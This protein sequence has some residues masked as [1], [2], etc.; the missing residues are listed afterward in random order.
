MIFDD[1]ICEVVLG[2]T[3]RKAVKR[4]SEDNILA[5]GCAGSGKTRSFVV[6]NIARVEGDAIIVDPNGEYYNQC[7]EE[8]EKKGT[9]VVL[10]D[11]KDMEDTKIT[12]NPFVSLKNDED[13]I[14]VFVDSFFGNEKESSDPFWVQSEKE[15][16]KICTR[17]MFST[18][19]K[20]D[21]NFETFQEILRNAEKEVFPM[22]PEK[23][24]MAIKISLAIRTDYCNLTKIANFLNNSSN[25]IDLESVFSGKRNTA[26]FL[27][28]STTDTALYPFVRTFVS[29]AWMTKV[30][31]G[32]GGKA[33]FFF[34]DEYPALG[35]TGSAKIGL[36]R[37]FGIHT[38]MVIQSIVQIDKKEREFVLANVSDVVFFGSLEQ[39]TLEYVSERC[40]LKASEKVYSRPVP[41]LS[42]LELARI[43]FEKCVILSKGSVPKID[44]KYGL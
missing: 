17:Q 7:K 42:D 35:F 3:T 4:T 6:P 30:R 22:C 11:F 24:F 40:G 38:Y 28:I 23:V 21:W 1:N 19:E 9:D 32:E 12:Y 34:L 43:P 44:K 29:D 37:K 39:E 5:I 10:L 25:S 2:E 26:V 18:Y 31:M 27:K 16:M 41:F 36:G 13:S 14:S 33:L 8:L 20:K 15:L